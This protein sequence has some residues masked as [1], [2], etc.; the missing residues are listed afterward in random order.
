M[1]PQNEKDETQ[2][3]SLPLSTPFGKRG[4]FHGGRSNESEWQRVKVVAAGCPRIAPALLSPWRHA[5]ARRAQD[6]DAPQVL[7]GLEVDR[8][9]VGVLRQLPRLPP[10]PRDE[11]LAQKDEDDHW[12]DG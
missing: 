11:Q 5:S 12:N 4:W 6:A 8:S 10:R 7:D 1:V 9:A 2:E 3:V